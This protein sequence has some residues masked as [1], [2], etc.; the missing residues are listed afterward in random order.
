METIEATVGILTFNS[1]ATLARTL[2]SVRMF[3]EILIC[4]GGSSDDTLAI[5]ARYGARVIAQ[6]VRY[7]RPDGR[8]EDFGG[9]RQQ[10]LEAATHEWFL[11]IDSDETVSDGLQEEIRSV[12]R[13][14]SSDVPGKPLVFRVPIGIIL[15]D[16]PIKYSSNFPGY[17]Y[18]FFNKKSG[19]HF[20]KPVHERIAFD[21]ARVTVGTFV[22]PW[23]TYVTRDE[24]R[25][26]L[27]ET[28]GYRAMEARA[29]APLSWGHFARHIVYRGVRTSLGVFFKVLRNYLL[30]GF[31]HSMPVSAE[32]GRFVAPYALMWATLREKLTL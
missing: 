29:Y 30:H 26:Y 13:L 32:W 27:R 9:V 1:S 12:V 24:V 18:R 11:Y 3:A 22:H 23:N 28:A 20:I 5:A 8:L 25:H 19:A 7:K 21:G 14:A 17:Q 6:D 10:M 31:A 16:T 4:D 2:E 15:D